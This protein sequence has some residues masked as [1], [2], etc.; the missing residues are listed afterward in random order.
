MQH[1]VPSLGY[2]GGA[3]GNEDLIDILTRTL[4]DQSKLFDIKTNIPQQQRKKTGPV[5]FS[6]L[7]VFSGL[8]F[9]LAFFGFS[10]SGFLLFSSGFLEV[11]N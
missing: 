9:T 6:F 5:F 4:P 1:R 2:Q 8:L 7:L 11:L 3:S 10:S